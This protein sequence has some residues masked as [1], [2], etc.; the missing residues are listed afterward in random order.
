[1]HLAKELASGSVAR[2]RWAP[3]LLAT[4]LLGLFLTALPAAAAEREAEPRVARV[5]YIEGEA[6]YLNADADEW[7]AVEV[8]APLVTGDRFYSGADGRAEIQLPAGVYARLSSN[9]ELDLLDVSDRTVHV[10]VGIGTATFRLRNTPA[11]QHV[12]IST[13]TTALVTRSRG[14]YR[15]DVAEDGQT[16]VL[17]RE[18][19]A[20]AYLGDERYRLDQGRGARI[21]NAA[22]VEDGGADVAPFEVFDASGVESDSWDEWERS[23]AVRTQSSPSRKYVGDVYGAEDLD[24]YGTW[25]RHE[26]YGQLW[27]PTQVAAGWAPFSQGRWVWQDPWGWTWVDYQPWGW[28]PSHHGRWV[29]VQDSWAW[30]PGPVIARP[31]YAPATVGF[32]GISV[33]TPS[34]SVS[35]GIG[36][37]VGWV[38]LG[39]GEPLIPWW[40]GFGGVRR[41]NPYWGGWGGP[42]IVNNKVINNTNITN[43]N[44]TNINYSNIERRG[45]FNA[46][47]RESFVRGDMQRIDLPKGHVRDFARPL[48]G[49]LEVIPQR[50]SLFAA[51]PEKLR[52]GKGRQPSQEVLQRAAVSTRALPASR[53]AFAKKLELIERDK[54]AAVPPRE[55]RRLAKEN[56]ESAPRVQSVTSRGKRAVVP[57]VTAQAPAKPGG[58]LQ[59]QVRD[60]R[61]NDRR[62]TL[63]TEM[64]GSKQGRGTAGDAAN[65]A[66]RSDRNALRRDQGDKDA[67]EVARPNE[68]KPPIDGDPRAASRER[69]RA[70]QPAERQATDVA[71]GQGRA[72]V[73]RDDAAAK[74][75]ENATR[76]KRGA[77]QR[78][79]AQDERQQRQQAERVQGEQAT[80]QK[81]DAEQ[82]EAAQAE[83]QQRQQAE[84]VQ[85]EQATRQ[86]RDAEQRE[87]AQVERQQRQQA[88]RVQGEQATRQKRDAEQRE[89]AQAE[90]QQRQ[91]AERTERDAAIRQQQG[92]QQQRAK[93]ERQQRRAEQRDESA[94]QKAQ[95]QP[96]VDKSPQAPPQRAADEREANRERRKDKKQQERA[97]ALP[98]G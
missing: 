25:D 14:I 56:N 68:G 45:G 92:A 23:R 58:P 39:Y 47:S 19:E 37:S 48:R 16:T 77:E 96:Q 34:V 8:N 18:G 70:E 28:A 93:V 61:A 98:S 15:V 26:T 2:T 78:K 43:V 63:Q 84:R 3:P 60:D 55:L 33:S 12:E 86:K 13:P 74:L 72:P 85:G 24:E 91:Q 50:E 59:R 11:G 22:Y 87:A 73:A 90:R 69:P 27:R 44:V 62:E 10:R 80:R 57:E 65:G 42:R 89:A 75:N 7:T 1:V 30:A 82:R 79:A 83:R 32:L 94:R 4:G 36:P 71:P 20:D 64:G 51:R 88:E 49:A 41:G 66:N 6:S 29:Y 97:R 67:A 76:Q 53:P 81:R 52:G 38:P 35:I 54:G 31:V 9:T 95:P 17:V 46:V 5:S 21:V 40:G